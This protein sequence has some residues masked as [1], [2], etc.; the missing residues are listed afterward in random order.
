MFRPVVN[1]ITRNSLNVCAAVLAAI[2]TPA[3]I[4]AQPQPAKP[5]LVSTPSSTRAVVMDAVT[6]LPQPFSATASSPLYGTDR[7]T[8]IT[9]FV[10]NLSLQPGDG[11]SAITA[12]AEDAAGHRYAL[13][14][15]FV[16]K[17]TG[18]DWLSQLN[19]RL[20]DS[21]GDLGDVLV[22]ITYR[23]VSSNRVRVAVGHLGGGPADDEGS[24][25]TPAPPYVISGRIKSAT[26]VMAGVTV[27]LSGAQTGVTT[28]DSNGAY[29]FVV[30]QVGNYTIT[31]AKVLYTFVPNGRTFIDL[32][33]NRTADFDATPPTF[34]ISGQVTDENNKP[35]SGA[36]VALSGTQ[37]GTTTTNANGIYS[38]TQLMAEGNFT[39]TAAKADYSI[40]PATRN[41][42]ALSADQTAN[43]S[44]ALVNYV[45]SGRVTDR[46]GNAISGL[47]ISLNGSNVSMT[48]VTDEAGVYI[49]S[50][51]AHGD[52]TFTPSPLIVDSDPQ[53]M[54]FN[55]LT[56]H[57]TSANY[58]AS[59]K[60]YVITGQL[61]DDQGNALDGIVVT[62]KNT[63]NDPPRVITTSNG[64]IFTF[65]GV[66]A[67]LSY[68]VTPANGV[69]AFT[70]QSTG[71]LDGNQVLN[72]SGPRNRYRINGVLTDGRTGLNGI[73]VTLTGG[74]NFAPLTVV[75]S[76]NGN[77][78]FTGLTSGYDYTVTP[79]S[80]AFYRFSSLDLI[81][82]VSDLSPSFLGTLRTYNVSGIVTDENN[83][84]MTGGSMALVS[85]NGLVARGTAIESDG[86]YEFRDVPALYS[87]TIYPYYIPTH[88][89]HT[90]NID[91]LASDQIVNFTGIRNKWTISGVVA[92]RLLHGVGGVNVTLSGH[93]DRTAT[94]DANGNYSFTDLPAGY[95]YKVSLSKIDYF[96]DPPTRSYYVLNDERADFTATRMYRISGRVTDS[97]GRGMMGMT[98]NVVGPETAR[99]ITA[100][101][102]SYTLTVT[103]AG[104]YLLTP[105][106]EQDFYAFTPVS[107]ALNI[108][109]HQTV[110]FTAAFSPPSSPTYVLEF[111]GTP[112]TVDYGLFWPEGPPLGHF[113]W[114]FW[115][116][117]GQDTYTRYMLSDG[118]GAAHALLF[119]FNYGL[120]GHYNLFGDIWD[121]SNANY[122]YSD[123]GPSAGEWG[124][125][126][127]GWDGQNIITYY[128]G[129]PVGKLPF[130]GPRISPGRSW[131][132]SLLAIGGS[133]HQNLIGRIAQVRG[134]EENNPRET[135][136]EAP[137]VPQT[138]FSLDGQLLSYFL[139]QSQNVADLS[140]GYQGSAH[141]GR[142]RGFD[143]GYMVECPDCPT[144][145]YVLDPSAPDFSNPSNPGQI[146][147]PFPVGPATPVAARVFD[148]FS[149]NNSTFI[150][151]GKGGLG[152]TETGSE[153]PLIWKM[154]ADP[155]YPQPF[156]ILN[157]HAVLLMNDPALAWV[158]LSA[159]SGNLDV[160]VDRTLG[161]YM[162][163]ANTGVTFRVVDQYNYFFAYTSNNESA[164]SA[165]KT[166]SVG[167]YQTGVRTVLVSGIPM[168]AFG[169]RTLRIVTLQTGSI[170][171]YAD[172][173]LV[174]STSNPLFVNA[175]GAG[176][177][178]NA[179]G[180]ALTNRWDNFTVLNAQ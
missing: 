17:V 139:R 173:T 114:E 163:G 27:T 112:A 60:P 110:N 107:K 11:A 124:H 5:I 108:T 180:L 55:F 49:M 143:H 155:A 138:L 36:T 39:V 54:T 87:Y 149:R 129:V 57:W 174:W 79:A 176:L 73:S 162:T 136:P 144:P 74:N 165:P 31:P 88:N 89:F 171:V 41:F 94:T 83:N 164:P 102:G 40:S 56:D 159:G 80:N 30:S 158:S 160:R 48:L 95:D 19:V 170:N 2:C 44:A 61:R 21:M 123:E 42:S 167:Y 140:S 24:A 22:R 96:F 98:M 103:T 29:S 169:W 132:A 92:D 18:N 106:K 101:D 8:R 118:Y 157:G 127:V 35:L 153:G 113:F 119:G 53:R 120:D 71:V 14:V 33:G 81:Y 77:F 85:G 70:P 45:I 26:T 116:M 75:S 151:G 1:T 152:S 50:L 99:V 100:S 51:K 154:N 150:L 23:G 147:A 128:N 58:T 122:F 141:T 62:L 7:V 126:A 137:F 38:F 117:P 72:F 67:G 105:S 168:P 172:G 161:T 6:F 104:N 179:A 37:Q 130:A 82:L 64:G 65:S 59:R 134:Y 68:V 15:E 90:G 91:S 86:R 66:P 115:A 156:G 125:Y 135:S 131:G 16:G 142:L 175:T 28:T 25:P 133:D 43:F 93:D 4:K 148:S 32:S 3:F 52:Y 109:D 20:N 166:L 13:Q 145:H 69:W 12:D 34:A 78:T 177:F 97:T 111:D 9:L 47:P 46:S 121:G 84:P 76:D 63:V 178:N 10:L 146:N